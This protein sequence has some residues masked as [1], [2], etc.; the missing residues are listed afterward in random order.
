MYKKSLILISVVL[1]VLC[2]FSGFVNATD[3]AKE[4]I[5]DAKNTVVDGAMQL[6]N[7]VR[8]G[9]GAVENGVENGVND[10]LNMDNNVNSTNTAR[11]TND[12]YTATRTAT[13]STNYNNSATLWVWLI[14]AIAAIVIIGLVWYYGSQNRTHTDE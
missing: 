4:M 8:N 6:G 1:F 3:S 2:I 7:D 5:T 10:V 9:V 11:K 12:G 14:V 13:N